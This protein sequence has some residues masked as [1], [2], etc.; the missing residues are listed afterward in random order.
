MSTFSSPE[1]SRKAGLPSALPALAVPFLEDGGGIVVKFLAEDL[2]DGRNH[3]A[4]H[5]GLVQYADKEPR[6]RS[7]F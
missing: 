2:P 5:S 7:R 4:R 1:A 3:T 6:H